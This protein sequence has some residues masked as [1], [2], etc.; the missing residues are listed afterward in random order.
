MASIRTELGRHVWIRATLFRGPEKVPGILCRNCRAYRYGEDPDRPVTGCM[1][2]IDVGKV[3][4]TRLADYREQEMRRRAEH[5]AA[6]R[7][8]EA[9]LLAGI[10]DGRPPSQFETHL[11]QLLEKELG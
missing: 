2:D 9:D 1:S 4:D 6:E 8:R 5:D 7:Q 3:G 10:D 11:Q